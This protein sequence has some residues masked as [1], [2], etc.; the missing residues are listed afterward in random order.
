MTKSEKCALLTLQDV[1]YT[2]KCGQDYWLYFIDTDASAPL[3]SSI[4]ASTGKAAW[5]PDSSLFLP[6]VSLLL[7]YVPLLHSPELVEPLLLSIT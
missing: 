4:I 2:N 5:L 3:T 1:K 7:W 6:V